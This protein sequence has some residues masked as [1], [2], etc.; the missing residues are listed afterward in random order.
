MDESTICV[1]W[2]LIAALLLLLPLIYVSPK[3]LPC[4]YNYPFSCISLILVFLK[5]IVLACQFSSFFRG[6]KLTNPIR[7]VHGRRRHRSAQL[8][9]DTASWVTRLPESNIGLTWVDFCG[10]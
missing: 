10:L 2:S 7:Q 1:I 5:F 3:A 9:P 6:H 8:I 4:I